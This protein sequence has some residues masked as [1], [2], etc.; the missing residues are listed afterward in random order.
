[1]SPARPAGRPEPPGSLDR[2]TAYP[3]GG[4]LPTV[5][6]G[7]DNGRLALLMDGVVQSISPPDSVERGGYWAA[8][9]PNLQVHR[10]LILG[11]GGGTLANLLAARW[12]PERIVGIEIDPR[13]VATS[14][15]Q[16]WLELPGLEVVEA[17]AFDYLESCRERFDYVAVDLYRGT[18]FAG[19]SLTKPFLRQVRDLLDAPG[20][21]AVNLFRDMRLEGR[22]ERIARMLQ[23]QREE[24]VGDNVIIHARAR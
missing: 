5:R 17:D 23:I 15:G 13:V 4:L 8:M 24:R 14:R 18:Q 16:G 1:L 2:P 19:R 3:P 21:V 12:A 10:A 22:R 20:L 7:E 9:L 11:L 6:L